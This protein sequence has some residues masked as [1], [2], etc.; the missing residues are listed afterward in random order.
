MTFRYFYFSSMI[1][2]LDL[3]APRWFWI[4]YLSLICVVFFSSSSFLSIFSYDE[5]N[6]WSILTSL[7]NYFVF[8]LLVGGLINSLDSWVGKATLICGLFYKYTYGFLSYTYY[9][10]ISLPNIKSRSLFSPAFYNNLFGL[11][12]MMKLVLCKG[13]K[14][15]WLR[16]SLNYSCFSY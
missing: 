16:P 13:F 7:S 2:S 5:N 9:C 1:F 4:R 14:L 3:S 11:G 6:S 15:N 10:L 12:L 8:L